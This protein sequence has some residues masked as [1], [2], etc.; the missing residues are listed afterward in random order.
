M[1]AGRKKGSTDKT[2]T[3]LRERLY[4]LF[5]E[6]VLKEREENELRAQFLPRSYYVERLFELHITNW[7]R[8]NILRLLTERV[9]YERERGK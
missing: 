9:R 2:V 3:A 5:D 6:M 4:R 7:S 8:R 1:K